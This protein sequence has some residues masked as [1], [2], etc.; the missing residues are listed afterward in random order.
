[1]AGFPTLQNIRPSPV[2]T[3]KASN[4]PISPYNAIHTIMKQV[5][6]WLASPEKFQTIAHLRNV[7]TFVVS[8]CSTSSS[9][10]NLLQ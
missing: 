1:M 10:N 5:D 4:A 7:L 8:R 9:E 3:R 6:N 2:Q